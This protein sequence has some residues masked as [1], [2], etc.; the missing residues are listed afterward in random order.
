MLGFG[1]GVDGLAYRAIDQVLKKFNL[2]MKDLEQSM[3]L[4][5]DDLNHAK[6]LISII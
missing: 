5:S 3:V 6:E 1:G 2:R 4:L